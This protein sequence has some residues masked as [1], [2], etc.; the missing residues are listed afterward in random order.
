MMQPKKIF[1]SADYIAKM[2]E[3]EFL[4]HVSY[5]S[6]LTRKQSLLSFPNKS[7]QNSLKESDF[8]KMLSSYGG[9]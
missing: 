3:F 7:R 6:D 9:S 4:L 5:S 2:H 8:D 1:V